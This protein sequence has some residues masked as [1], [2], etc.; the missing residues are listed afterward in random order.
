M[1]DTHL[2]PTLEAH[3]I[4]ASEDFGTSNPNPARP[5]GE[6]IAARYGRRALLGASAA[7]ALAALPEAASAQEVPRSGGPS[8]LGFRELRHGLAQTDEVAEGHETQIVIRWGDPVLP[9]APDF[10]AGRTTPEAQAGQ[11]GYNCDY[12]DFFPLPAGSRSSDH[13]LLVVNHEYTNTNLMWPGLGAGRAARQRVSAE[14]A[15]AEL[16]AHGATVIEIRREGGRWSYVKDSRYNRRITGETPIRISGPAAGHALLKTG[17][18]PTGARVLGMLNNCAGGNTPWG[19]VL[20][21]EENF[22]GYFGGDPAKTPHAQAFRRYGISA[23]PW[24]GW[25]RH[26]DRFDVEKE[27]N[28]PNRFGWVVEFDPYDPTSEPVKRTALGRFKHEGCHHAV[29]R[30][31]RGCSTWAM[32]SASSSSTASSP[33][34]RGTRTT[35]PPTATC[36]MRARCRW[37]SSMTTAGSSGSTS[38]TGRGR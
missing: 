18:D 8:S 16:M 38:C 28:E 27:P 10:A 36:S 15:R 1:P 32:T 13:G 21:A 17:A 22:N 31:G 23:E 26:F 37:R 2:P 29:N 25:S 12:L 11:F 7:A 20:T 5:I 34:A 14:Q 24:Y 3:V 30:D 19:T 6:I 33:P 4:D 35:A 9:G